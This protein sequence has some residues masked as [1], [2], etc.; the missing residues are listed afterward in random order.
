MRPADFCADFATGRENEY[1]LQFPLPANVRGSLWPYHERANA[2][3]YT[4]PGCEIDLDEIVDSELIFPNE[5]NQYMK[6]SGLDLT[7]WTAHL[8]IK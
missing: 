1:E 6:F 7:F 2:E 4:G 3:F 5:R 8:E